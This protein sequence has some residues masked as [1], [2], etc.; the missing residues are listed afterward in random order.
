M[1]T[2]TLLLIVL[3]T[4]SAVAESD[5]VLQ[6]MHAELERSKSQLKLENMGAPYYIDY[7]VMD[8]DSFEADAAYGAVRSNVRTQLR[9]IRVVVRVG[10]YKQDSLYGQGM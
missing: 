7:R 5:P 2:A 6:A 8:L 9:Y 1:K 3:L 10:S 4:A